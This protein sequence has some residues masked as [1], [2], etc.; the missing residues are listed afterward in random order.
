[1]SS[2]QT[3]IFFVL[4]RG[5]FLFIPLLVNGQNLLPP[6]NNYRLLE[7]KGAS[8]N[9]DLSVNTN[10]ELFVANNK[11]L[12]HFNGEQWN[13]NKLPNNTIIRSV[14]SVGDRIYTGSY[15]EFGYWKKN[16]L[17]E[18][19]YA[20]LTHLI[21]DHEFTSEEFWEILPVNDK[22]L[23]RSFS[24]IYSYDGNKIKVVDPPQV[25][26]DFIEYNDRII[27]AG[28]LSGLF[29]LKND[30]L[31]P[32]PNQELL[33][34]KTVTDMVVFKDKLLV[35]TK[36]S[37]C[38]LFDGTRLQPWT[39]DINEELKLHQLNKMLLLGKDEIGFGTIKN[40]PKRTRY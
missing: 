36:L 39:P 11:G 8:K 2:K 25:I 32:L 24:S 31:V 38:Y 4:L 6:I 14:E 17:G 18:L 16:R 28:G 7:Y 26:S 20:S 29:V 21:K 3:N 23:F 1:M 12:L 33:Q 15:E 37:G 30:E 40:V 35:G 9:W 34:G 19:E 10:G 22:V 5:I 27:V 13:L